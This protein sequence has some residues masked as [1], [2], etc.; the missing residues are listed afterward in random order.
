MEAMKDVCKATIFSVSGLTCFD[1]GVSEWGN[2]INGNI[3]HPV[4][5]KVGTVKLTQG[6]ETSKY[7]QEE[8][9]IEILAVAA[10]DPRKAQTGHSNMVGVVGLA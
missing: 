7:L 9:S 8:K 4:L 10:S 5:S 2:P 3:N 6:T 1:P